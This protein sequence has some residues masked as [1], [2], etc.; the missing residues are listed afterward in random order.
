MLRELARCV[1]GLGLLERAGEVSAAKAWLVVFERLAHGVQ[2]H[3]RLDGQ[4]SRHLSNGIVS[5]QYT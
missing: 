5:N 1:H 4:S 2:Q 3:A